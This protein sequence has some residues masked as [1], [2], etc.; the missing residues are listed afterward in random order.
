MDLE[1]AV[2][3]VGFAR[4]QAFELSSCCLCMQLLERRL[5]LGNNC[6]LAFGL[7]QLDQLQRFLDFTLDPPAAGDRLI[8]PS[9]LTQQFLST[10][11]VV[12]QARIFGLCV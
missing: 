12:P 10:Y 8:Q 2:I 11:R 1:V 3:A 9:T 5:G 4:Q 7:T 6:R